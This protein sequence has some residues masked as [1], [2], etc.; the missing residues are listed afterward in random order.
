[1]TAGLHELLLAPAPDVAPR[2]LGAVLVCARPGGT[3]G[4]RLTE[5]EAYGGPQDSDLPDPGAHTYRG[6]TAR[7]ASMFGPPGHVYVYFTYGLH[8]AVNFVC[9]PEGVGG[10]VLIRSGE[11]VLGSEV[12]T[13]RRLA[14]RSSGPAFASLARG[15]GNVAQALALT[16]DDDG[17]ALADLGIAPDPVARARE[18]VERRGDDTWA[19]LVLAQRP[20]SDVVVTARTGVSGEG[21]TDAYPWR[22]AL[23][24]EPTVSPYRKATVKRRRTR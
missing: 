17:A 11:V 3:V 18:E 15:P 1:M 19:G 21:G 6:R 16:R 5:V 8:H 9:R 7:N 10:G 12:A 13:Q 23:P 2:L 20:A 4:L 14:N 22:Y 24:G